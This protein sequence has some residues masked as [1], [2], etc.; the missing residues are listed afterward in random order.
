MNQQIAL[1][2]CYMPTGAHLLEKLH[3]E[4]EQQG[5]QMALCNPS[6]SAAGGADGVSCC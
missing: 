1:Y 3:A 6:E 2:V 5:V 4:M